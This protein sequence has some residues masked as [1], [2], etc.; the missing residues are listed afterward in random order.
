MHKNVAKLDRD[1]HKFLA[2]LGLMTQHYDHRH[3]SKMLFQPNLHVNLQAEKSFTS[4][5]FTIF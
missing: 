1:F 3:R 2:L 4:P 5:L